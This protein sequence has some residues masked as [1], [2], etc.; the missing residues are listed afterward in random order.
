MALDIGN[1]MLQ[2]RPG[3]P[4]DL[5]NGGG[6]MERERLRLA[7]EQ[8]EET[9]RQ[10]EIDRDLREREMKGRQAVALLGIEREKEKAALKEQAELLKQRQAAGLK[11]AEYGGEGKV[12]AIESMVPYM[13]S[14]GMGVENL[15]TVGGLPS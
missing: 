10:N 9:K 6:G 12:E 3:Q 7:R 2:L 15:G 1:L 5:G 13:S 11:A 4:I 8:F 14:L